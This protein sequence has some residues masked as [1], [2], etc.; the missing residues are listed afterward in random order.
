MG[1][2]RGSI[3]MAAA[4]MGVLALGA[5]PVLAAEERVSERVFLV[6]D[7]PGTPTQ[8]QM[9]VLAGCSD[10]GNGQCKG[11]AHY[12]EH[13]VLVGRNPEHKDIAVRIFPDASSNGWTNTRATAYVHSV[14]ARQG[15]PKA[16]LER[17]F[18]FYAARLKDFAITEEDAARE[19]NVVLQEHDWRV[20]SSPFRSFE[21]RIDRELLPDHPSGLWT[22]GTRENIASLTLAEAKTF[23]ASW[24]VINNV[25]FVVKAN[26]D[27]GDLKAIAA[28]ALAGLET[29]PLPARALARQPAVDAGRRD[30]READTHVKHASVIYKKLVSMD[31]SNAVAHMAVRTVLMDFLRSRL[32][33]SPYRALV[34][35]SNLASGAPQLSLDRVAPKSFVLRVGADV[36][37]DAT[38]EALLAAIVGYVDKLSDV[39][40]SPEVVERLKRRLANSRANAD[41]D[42]SMVFSRLIGWIASRNSYEAF[43]DWSTR[44]GAVSAADVAQIAVAL[45]GPG[46]VV[47]GVLAPAAEEASK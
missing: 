28:R 38:A 32:P 21:R 14:P 6:R 10:E 36:A 7:A 23:H 43:A 16:D 2:M 18:A 45:A 34:E 9:I 30:L 41:Q 15:G 35:S 17:L 1:P 33:G 44:V 46:K 31:E 8:F 11:L 25:Y 37:P 12:L 26:I 19:R 20:G 29:K 22:I 39:T 5:D 24:Y 40:P 47:T 3:I 4:C 42:P 27:P 13:L